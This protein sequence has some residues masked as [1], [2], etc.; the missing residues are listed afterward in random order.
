M[1]NCYVKAYYDWI[2]QTC[3]LS[4]AEK[5]RLFIS[6]L[7]YAR[8]GLIPE[9][10]G[11]EV[12]MFYT[13]K[14]AI[15]RD[16]AISAIKS[17]NGAKGGRGN[18]AKKANES[19]PKQTKANESKPKLTKEEDIR[20]KTEDED[21]RQKTK[22]EDEGLNTSADADVSP[23]GV[24]RGDVQT[25]IDAWNSLGLNPIRGIM[26]NTTRRQLLNGRL[27]QYGLPTVLQA[28][29]NVRSSAF[30][31]G[32]NNRGFTATFDWVVKPTNFQKV[33]DGNYNDRRNPVA[34]STADR[35]SQMIEE[36]AFGD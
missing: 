26:P 16:N 23:T 17:E 11:R 31:N 12:A 4:D 1:A 33:L 14:A 27:S 2:E 25:V 28:I 35:L 24:G 29:E 3:I 5:G 36:G 9:G 8:S 34:K 20:Q 7:E 32:Q 19:K 10:S 13:F 6:I 21:I 22:T 18:K 15:D 30:L